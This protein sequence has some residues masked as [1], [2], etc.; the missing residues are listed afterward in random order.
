MKRISSNCNFSAG[1]IFK[2]RAHLPRRQ[3]VP[4]RVCAVDREAAMQAL[5]VREHLRV[6]VC[7]VRTTIAISHSIGDVKEAERVRRRGYGERRARMIH[8]HRSILAVDAAGDRGVCLKM[9][10]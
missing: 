8:A 1:M 3:W 10:M 2:S 7:C 4:Q 5:M 6:R 9:L